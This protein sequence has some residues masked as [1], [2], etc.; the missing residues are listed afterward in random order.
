MA[1]RELQYVSEHTSLGTA[2]V[3]GTDAGVS[4]VLLGDDGADLL[5]TLR[6][7]LPGASFQEGG[8]ALHALAARVAAAVESP[9]LAADIPL[10][11]QGTP[12]QQAVWQALRAIPAGQTA[13][14]A[15]LARQIGRP[16]AIRAVGQACGAN[17]VAVLVPCHR[18]VRSDGSLSGYR[19]GVERKRQLLAREAAA[20]LL[21]AG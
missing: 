6:A 14:Y 13:S 11:L 10:D 17:L 5:R 2:L 8:E 15:E 3:A 20:R 16:G 21:L 18:A 4:A 1:G 19:W 12:F 7:R 9:A